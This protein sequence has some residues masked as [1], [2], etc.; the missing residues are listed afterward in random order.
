MH[1]SVS[2]SCF[3]AFKLS[4]IFILSLRCQSNR[5]QEVWNCFTELALFLF[6]LASLEYFQG[7]GYCMYSEGF[8]RIFKDIKSDL[9]LKANCIY[10]ISVA[11]C[12]LFFAKMVKI[13]FT[14]REQLMQLREMRTIY[15]IWFLNTL[16]QRLLF[17]VDTSRSLWDSNIICIL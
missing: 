5:E 8:L 11:E 1:N 4:P 9:K 2:Q 6:H 14:A 13:E 10:S 3:L 17:L 7:S 16:E 15:W 12:I